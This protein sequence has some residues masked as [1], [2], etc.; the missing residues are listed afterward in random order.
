VSFGVKIERQILRIL[1]LDDRLI[2]RKDE[3]IEIERGLERRILIE[4]A[5]EWN[6]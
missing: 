6:E 1:L 3:V 2:L 5:A 4:V